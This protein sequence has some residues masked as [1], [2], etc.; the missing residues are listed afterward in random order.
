MNAT[1]DSQVSPPRRSDGARDRSRL[2]SALC[3]VLFVPAAA[4]VGV[5]TLTSERASRC[6]TYGGDECSTSGLPAGLFDWGV[7][8]A[9]A[10]CLTALLAPAVRVRR[11]ALAVQLAAECAAL[12][13]I[14]GH[15]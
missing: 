2:W 15:A 1:A 12:L 13:A 5:L 6:M 11:A 14:L 10:A 4:A 3:A 8:L 9:V 7:G